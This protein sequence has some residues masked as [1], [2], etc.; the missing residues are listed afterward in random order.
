MSLLVQAVVICAGAV[1]LACA[2]ALALA[3][4]EVIILERNTDFGLETSARNSE[5]IHAA[6]RKYWPGLASPFQS[7]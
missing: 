1:G 6:I 7:P 2:R 3:G 4:K 5:V